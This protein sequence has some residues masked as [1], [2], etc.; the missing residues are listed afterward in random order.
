MTLDSSTVNLAE[1]EDRPEIESTRPLDSLRAEEQLHAWTGAL[2]SCYGLWR[3]DGPR[4][5]ETIGPAEV[6]S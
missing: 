2:D 4:D 6:D 3:G 1:P 5:V